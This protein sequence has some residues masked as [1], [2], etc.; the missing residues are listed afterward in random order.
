MQKIQT[1]FMYGVPIS[2]GFYEE[3]LQKTS[4]PDIYLVEKVL[5]RKGNKMYVKWLGLDRKHNSWIENADV[6]VV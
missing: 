3:E 1:S 5:R 6:V 4:N 2:G